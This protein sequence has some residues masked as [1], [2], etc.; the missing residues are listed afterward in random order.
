M[1]WGKASKTSEKTENKLLSGFLAQQWISWSQA[2]VLLDNHSRYGSGWVSAS[3]PLFNSAQYSQANA[4]NEIDSFA[5]TVQ[6][7]F[8]KRE[9]VPIVALAT[10]NSEIK[11]SEDLKKEIKSI[12][13]DQLPFSQSQDVVAQEL[14][15]RIIRMHFSLIKT[16]DILEKYTKTAQKLC[17]KQWRGLWNCDNY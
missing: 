3:N 2:D 17:D 7:E 9:T 15:L 6:E 5:E 14:Q 8:S 16:I 4:K 12:F 13:E 1:R 10:V 11:A